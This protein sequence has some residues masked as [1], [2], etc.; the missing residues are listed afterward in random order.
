MMQYTAR[1]LHGIKN[2]VSLG[3]LGGSVGQ[4]AAF[5]SGHDPGIEPRI[6]LPARREACFSLSLCLPLCPPAL[7]ISLSNKQTK[8]LKKKNKVVIEMILLKFTAT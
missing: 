4:A 3:R 2:T 7:S 1:R 6:G 5:G 8:S